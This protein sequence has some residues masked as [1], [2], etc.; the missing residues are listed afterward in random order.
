MDGSGLDDQQR[1]A[2]DRFLEAFDPAMLVV[3]AGADGVIGGCLVGFAA[4]CSIEPRRFMV[5]LSV[6]NRTTGIAASAS[7][8]AVHALDRDHVDLA[9]RFGGTSGPEKFDGLDWR[10][11]NDG[12][13]LLD[14]RR[15][16][17]GRIDHWVR[18]GDHAGA[19][20]EPIDASAS[21]GADPLRLSDV[22]HVEPG[23]EAGP[24]R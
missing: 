1:R 9:E 12:T 8:L 19:V 16:F 21:G 20:L 3:T 23:R 2:N 14:V 7:V 4:P 10:P 13:P 18:L 6:T 5:G 15:W 17:V 24:P 22:Q 11:W